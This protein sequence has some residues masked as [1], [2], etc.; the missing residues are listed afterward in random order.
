[1]IPEFIDYSQHYTWNKCSWLWLERYV[2]GLVRAYPTGQRDDSL[3]IGS[4]VHAGV[5]N[6]HRTKTIAIPPEAINEYTPTPDAY[7]SCA[8]MVQGWVQMYGGDE[9]EIQTIEKALTKTDASVT[10][11]AKIDSMFVV[12]KPTT[13]VDGFGNTISLQEGYYPQEYKTKDP[14]IDRTRWA[15][16]WHTNMQAS[17]QMITA[18]ENFKDVPGIVVNVIEKP[19]IYVPKRKCK[20]CGQQFEYSSYIVGEDGKHACVVCGHVQKLSALDPNKPNMTEPQYWR[21]LVTRT[22][23]QL[24]QHEQEICETRL[25]MEH[26][27]WAQ[28]HTGVYHSPNRDNC[29]HTIWGQCEYE[30]VH[31]NGLWA[32]DDRMFTIKD[33]IKYAITE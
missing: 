33:T 27:D 32:K 11:L 31:T 5:E 24:Q 14:K 20:G 30:P 23:Q 26:L 25:C 17:Y 18:I 2:N 3:A 7:A 10:I 4:L 13:L 21:F 1:M 15:A 12:R 16:Q 19:T 8:K 28:T 29:N 9:W 22:P 6:F